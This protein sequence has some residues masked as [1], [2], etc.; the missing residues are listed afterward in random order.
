MLNQGHTFV[1]LFFFCR[2][3]F[4]NHLYMRTQQ[5]IRSLIGIRNQNSEFFSNVFF[6]ICVCFGDCVTFF[7]VYYRR[8]NWFDLQD[9]TRSSKSRKKSNYTILKNV[10]SFPRYH[11]VNF[12]LS[13]LKNN[14]IHQFGAYGSFARWTRHYL[15]KYAESWSGGRLH[16]I[17]KLFHYPL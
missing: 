3:I 4:V 7:G 11:S 8:S 10:I 5:K 17:A 16:H 15:L 13:L 14:W 1:L 6:P 2:F 12:T 9:D